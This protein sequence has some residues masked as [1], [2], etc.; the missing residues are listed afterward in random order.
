MSS[1]NER[2]NE[3]WIEVQDSQLSESQSPVPARAANSAMEKL[4][5]EAQKESSSGTSRIDSPASS[6]AS[7]RCSNGDRA[8]NSDS[9]QAEPD[10]MPEL[11]GTDWVWDWSSRPE[12]IP[13]SGTVSRLKHPTPQRSRFS[14]R[15]TR[16]MHGLYYSM[17]NLPMLLLT[18][19]CS[20]I[21]GATTMFV[22]LRR[23]NS[24]WSTSA[25]VSSVSVIA[26]VA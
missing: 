21:L 10:L 22:C 5:L 3:S 23:W 1:K 25:S 9:P 7:S 19:A 20:F 18:H 11:K 12:A 6:K 13:P 15:N 17:E 8:A 26:S 24:Y 2:L 14:I 16:I 4:L